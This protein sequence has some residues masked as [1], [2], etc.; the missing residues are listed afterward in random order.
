M[1][2]LARMTQ[3]SP[4]TLYLVEKEVRANP[5]FVEHLK[6]LLAQKD[7]AKA[8][9]QDQLAALQAYVA[10]RQLP[11]WWWWELIDQTERMLDKELYIPRPGDEGALLQRVL[12]VMA[13]RAAR[14]VKA[15]K[16][17][18][19]K[20]YA[21]VQPMAG[22]GGGP[23]LFGWRTP[24]Q[25]RKHKRHERQ[26]YLEQATPEER[27]RYLKNREK[28][29]EHQKRQSLAYRFDQAYQEFGGLFGQALS[30]IG[31][32]VACFPPIG[33]VIGAGMMI[34]GTAITT[35]Q[36][37]YVAMQVARAQAKELEQISK[38]F[39][40]GT[41]SEADAQAQM[42]ELM[43]AEAAKLAAEGKLPPES[44]Q[45]E[46]AKLDLEGKKPEPTEAKPIPADPNKQKEEFTEMIENRQPNMKVPP[47]NE[48]PALAQNEGKYLQEQ[49]G[50]LNEGQASA[51]GLE[52]ARKAEL[53]K[54]SKGGAMS[55][56]AIVGAAALPFIIRR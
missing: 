23:L 4:G 49:S 32:V 16:E 20:V 28:R 53:S 52:P 34:A 30:T 29:K 50:K 8:V 15:R 42:K 40:A 54:E 22:M 13:I 56:A 11:F 26:R 21:T 10:G 17:L 38:D 27:E 35:H 14:A 5:E 25:R 6:Q 39:E 51:V 48:A 55:T 43:E 12:A 1:N 18:P 7:P 47:V 36:Q 45:V 2:V 31:G 44:A 24:A 33:T 9:F 41:I 19:W 3:L 37:V 46:E